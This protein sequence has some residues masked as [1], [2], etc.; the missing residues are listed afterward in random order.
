[1]VRLRGERIYLGNFE[2]YRERSGAGLPLVLEREALHITYNEQD[3][4]LVE[5]RT[6]GNDSSPAQVFRYP[7]SN[8]LSSVNLELDNMGQ[9][10][11]YEEV[12]SIWQY[13]LSGN[14]KR[15]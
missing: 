8:H 1:M 15:Y 10:I 13:I 4:V 2:V 3:I 7:F 9:I 11:S 6:H 5:S 12:L 14:A